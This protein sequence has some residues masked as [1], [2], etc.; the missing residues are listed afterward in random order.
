M[1]GESSV[2]RSIIDEP[3]F[4]DMQGGQMEDES[5]IT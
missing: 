3:P 5:G 4:S 1:E 2:I